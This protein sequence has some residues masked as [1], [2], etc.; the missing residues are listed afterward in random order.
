[1]KTVLLTAM[2]MLALAASAQ[3]IDTITVQPPREYLDFDRAKLEIPL[4]LYDSIL[5][6]DIKEI[7]FG[8]VFLDGKTGIYDFQNLKL[9]TEIKYE[10]LFYRGTQESEYDTYHI[11]RWENDEEY[12]LISVSESD[13]S[14]MTVAYKKEKEK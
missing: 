7:P 1:M 6:G 12:G 5:H 9:M 2:L 4:Q 14:M 8:F 3:S 10:S 13:G 11:F